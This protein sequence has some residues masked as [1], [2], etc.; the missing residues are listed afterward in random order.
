[1][2]FTDDM[3]LPKKLKEESNWRLKALRHALE[4]TISV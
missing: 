3:V 1:M 2:F 4:C